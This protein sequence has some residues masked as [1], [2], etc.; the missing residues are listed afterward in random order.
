MLAL[1]AVTGTLTETVPEVSATKRVVP[2]TGVGRMPARMV[3]AREAT[4]T[5]ETVLENDGDG[6]P[7]TT[8]GEDADLERCAA[9]A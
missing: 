3:V 4:P 8:T 1:P 6:P 2:A 5:R 7:V 9:G